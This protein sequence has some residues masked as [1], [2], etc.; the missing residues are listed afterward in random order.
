MAYFNTS[1]CTCK[2]GDHSDHLNLVAV[3]L[4][5]PFRSQII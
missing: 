5:T 4:Y 2:T 3:I 1:G